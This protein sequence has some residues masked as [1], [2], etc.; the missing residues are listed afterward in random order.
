MRRPARRRRGS[1]RVSSQRTA[2]RRSRHRRPCPRKLLPNRQASQDRRTEVLAGEQEAKTAQMAAPTLPLEVLEAVMI[3]RHLESARLEDWQGLAAAQTERKATTATE[4]ATT[5]M[6]ETAMVLA[7][8]WW[9]R[10]RVNHQV[11]Q[12][13]ALPGLPAR[14]ATMATATTI[15]TMTVREAM[16]MEIPA[17][18]P[19]LEEQATWGLEVVRTTTRI[20]QAGDRALDSALVPTAMMA[21]AP[22]EPTPMDRAQFWATMALPATET[23]TRLVRLALAEAKTTTTQVWRRARATKIAS[24]DWAATAKAQQ[25][26]CLVATVPNKAAAQLRAWDLVQDRTAVL[27]LPAKTVM[28]AQRLVKAMIRARTRPTVPALTPLQI[29]EQTTDQPRD[30][31]T[32]GRHPTRA[33]ALQMAIAQATLAPMRASHL[34][35]TPPTALTAAVQEQ[36]QDQIPTRDL[37]RSPAPAQ[38]RMRT[39][40]I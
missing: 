39:A 31:A 37:A 7:D 1:S 11:I 21:T 4:A 35:E 25:P 17:L 28:L 10:A 34:A 6:E 19:R 32:L 5:V 23:T 40:Q 24:P 14:P 22:K 2:T 8:P 18:A 16:M 29:P 12:T 13:A 33:M 26:R 27:D 36:D 30:K 15:T 20:A 9:D 3:Q 38:A